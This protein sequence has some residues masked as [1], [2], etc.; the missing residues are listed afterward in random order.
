MNEADLKAK[1]TLIEDYK[2]LKTINEVALQALQPGQHV[3]FSCH[4]SVPVG[5]FATQE[6][7]DIGIDMQLLAKAMATIIQEMVQIKLD[8][9]VAILKSQGLED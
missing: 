2:Y 1:L 9:Q 7:T 4:I 6:L 5:G 3:A 8:E